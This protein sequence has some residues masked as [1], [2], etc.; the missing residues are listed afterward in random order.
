MSAAL[1]R[2]VKGKAITKATR[3]KSLEEKNC[4]IGGV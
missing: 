2:W 1:P 4:K 3:N